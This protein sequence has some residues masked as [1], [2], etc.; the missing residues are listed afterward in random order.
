[1]TSPRGSEVRRLVEARAKRRCEYCRSPLRFAVQSFC[2]EHI[3]PE[4]RGG[5]SDA[6]NLAFACQG[7]NNHKYTKTAARDPVSGAMVTLYHPRAQRWR[8]HFAWSA[9]A[10]I[11]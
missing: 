1:M 3:V 10:T 11:I 8:E 6:S 7:C 2:V 5:S 9:D 4:A